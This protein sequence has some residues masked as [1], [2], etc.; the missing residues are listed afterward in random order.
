MEVEQTPGTTTTS[1]PA[2]ENSFAP[3]CRYRGPVERASWA[4]STL[5]T[6]SDVLK[7][8]ASARTSRA[9]SSSVRS[10]EGVRMSY[11]R[12]MERLRAAMESFYTSDV[13]ATTGKYP[14]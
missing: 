3:I 5:D 6:P 10:S 11:A 4:M 13:L 7:Y 12:N 2:P 1:R 9:A 14:E 8:S